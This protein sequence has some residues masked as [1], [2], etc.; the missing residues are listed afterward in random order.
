MVKP[1]FA[2]LVALAIALIGLSTTVA[3]TARDAQ[4]TRV[5]DRTVACSVGLQGGVHEVEVRARTGTRLF[6]D[7]SK[8]RYTASTD[9]RA[10]RGLAGVS[11]GGEPQW[12]GLRVATVCPQ[13]GARVDFS[14]RGLTGNTASPL[15]D[16][17]D[18]VVPGRVLIRV[19][20]VFREPTRLRLWRQIEMFVARGTVV[21]GRL[22]I[23]TLSGR[24]VAVAKVFPSGRA[25]IFV[26]RTC[27]AS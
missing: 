16:S 5:I 14:T 18:C 10:P 7:P 26:A 23:S 22:A 4:T 13:V 2:V 25:V 6:D 8:W 9:A 1:L 24:R 15:E 17:Y 3:A 20:A 19:R 21:E 11:A 27:T 12:I